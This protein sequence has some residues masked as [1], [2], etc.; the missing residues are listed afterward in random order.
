MGFCSTCGHSH[1]AHTGYKGKCK[2]TNCKCK[3]YETRYKHHYK[4][5]F[6]KFEVPKGKV[7]S[8]RSIEN[9]ENGKRFYGDVF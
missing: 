2:R 1:I 4:T 6:N 8:K 7:Y 3:E 9:R 5:I